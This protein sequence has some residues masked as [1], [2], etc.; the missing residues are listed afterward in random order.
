MGEVDRRS[1]LLLRE[2]VRVID[3]KGPEDDPLMTLSNFYARVDRESGGIALHMTRLVAAPAGWRG[4][5]LI[6]RIG[7]G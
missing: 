6:Y 1:G 3:D 5:A 4:D 7:L 2:T